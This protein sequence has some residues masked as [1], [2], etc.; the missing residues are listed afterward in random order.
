MA[1]LSELLR[2]IG[3]SVNTMKDDLRNAELE[4]KM[5]DIT[6]RGAGAGLPLDPTRGV[7]NKLSGNNADLVN[8]YVNQ[9]LPMPEEADPYMAAFEFFRKMS[10][11]SSIPGQTLL[12]ATTLSVGAPIDYLNA[13]DAERRK[14]EQARAALGLQI[15]PSLKPKVTK[16]TYGTP[17]F[18]LVSEADG[19]G[20]MTEAV[21][22]P[23]TPKDF[24]DIRSQIEAGSVVVS[25]MP[26]KGDGAQSPMGK[27]IA[28]YDGGKGDMTTKQFTAAYEKLTNIAESGDSGAQ[29]PFGKLIADYG[30]G[31]GSMTTEQ[32]TAAYEKLTETSNPTE[33]SLEKLQARAI[34]GGL[35]VDSDEYKEFVLNNGRTPTGFTVETSP[36]GSVKFV[37]GDI[38][39]FNTGKITP[40]YVQLDLGNGP[41][42]Q[43]IPG[44]EAATEV[45]LQRTGY[46]VNIENADDLLRNVEKIIGRPKGDG[47]AAISPNEFLSG[48][49]GPIEGLRD[50]FIESQG[51]TDLVVK[52]RFLESNAFT[53]AFETLKGAGA[54]TEGEGKAATA[55]LAMLSRV[56]S[57]KAF[58][59]GLTQFA[60]IIRAGRERQRRLISVLPQVAGTISGGANVDLDFS[61]MDASQIK[62]IDVESLTNEQKLQLGR[63]LGVIK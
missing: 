52:I 23:L 26:T 35:I 37:Q 11:V 49:L 51:K 61:T 44:S 21:P 53:Q 50:T 41:V 13:K 63:K 7:L 58:T 8:Q 15:A 19:K 6:D 42:E 28:D 5:V 12:G 36:D 54:I 3:G 18:Y 31:K 62:L 34:A 33:T 24:A 59:E 29:S 38:G 4:N 57:E 48:V 17:D 2:D 22:T 45:E 32:F 16:A 25:P 43:V 30:D 1:T 46:E 39:D 56:Q 27:L 40:G 14:V 20:G 9:A 47:F 55:A 10:E 60:N